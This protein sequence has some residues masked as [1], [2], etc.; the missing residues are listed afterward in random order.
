VEQ[1][2]GGDRGEA[3]RERVPRSS[4]RASASRGPE[5]ESDG[6]TA[7]GKSDYAAAIRLFTEAR[8]DT[9]PP[10]GGPGEEEK[11]RQRSLVK[12]TSI[13]RRVAA[14]RA[15]RL[16]A[17]ADKVARD[18]FDQ[19]RRAVEAMSWQSKDLAPRRGIRSADRYGES[20][21]RARAVRGR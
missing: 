6:I 15:R 13:R 4:S 7:L 21:V 1:P 5:Q 3:P 19:L 14:A 20:V 17:E 11:E 10:A 2:G 18:V 8:S 9:R 12:S 16:C